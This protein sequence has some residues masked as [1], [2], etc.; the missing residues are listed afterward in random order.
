M[1]RFCP[2]AT[3]SSGNSLFIGTDNTKILI[4]AGISC[5][6][7]TARLAALG[8]RLAD[9]DAIF[10]THEHSDHVRG[11][12][13][14]T[15]RRRVPVY[16]T[17]PTWYKV[18]A[19]CGNVAGKEYF[20]PGDVIEVG[21]LCLE[22]VPLPH[23]AADPVGFCVRCGGTKLA[24]ATDLG[25]APSYLVRLFTGARL[26]FCEANHDEEMLK[27][28]SYPWFL[29]Q[30]ILGGRGHLSNAA[31]GAFLAEAAA[32]GTAYIS[33]GHLSLNNNLPD[34]ARLTVANALAD[35]GIVTGRDVSL[36]LNRHGE[37]GECIDLE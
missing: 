2:L 18:E 15:S 34:L 27:V 6:R 8:V 26:I 9:L 5:R 23:D 28:G 3:G 31:A 33:L 24:I 17:G 25:H 16:A 30:R 7:L 4:D 11:L 32:D 36:V 35:C 1:F 13:T 19:E 21:D 22:A 29:K 10:I 37:M 12:R 20:T 14:L